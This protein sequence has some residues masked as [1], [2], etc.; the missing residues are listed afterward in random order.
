M[1]TLFMLELRIDYRDGLVQFTYAP[2]P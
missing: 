2:P 1:N